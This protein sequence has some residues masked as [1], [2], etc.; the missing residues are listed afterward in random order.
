M[1][2]RIQLFGPFRQ[3]QAEPTLEL[4]CPAATTLADVR[5]ALDAYAHSNWPEY[6]T[7]LLRSSAFATASAVLRDDDALP[8][9]GQLAILPPVNGG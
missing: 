7:S 4:D 9:D 5:V 1:K 3:F 2:L 6:R 8:D